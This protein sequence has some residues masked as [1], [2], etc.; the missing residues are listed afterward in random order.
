MHP[1]KLASASQ[2]L[3]IFVIFY[4]L[5]VACNAEKKDKDT[6]VKAYVQI[7][8][9]MKDVMWKGALDGQ[10]SLDTLDQK[11]MLN[12][13]GPEAF[14]TGELL[15]IDGK[16][17]VGRVAT[18]TSMAIGQTFDVKA[19][20]F[21]Y[22]Y[23]AEWEKESIPKT[24]KSLTDFENW[25][26]LKIQNEGKPFAFKL[27]GS[28]KSAK[29]HLQNLPEGTQVSSPAEAHQG[30]QTYSVADKEVTVLGFFS[31]AHQGV[32][33]HHDSFIHLHLITKDLSLMGHV[34]SLVFGNSPITL[35]LPK[36]SN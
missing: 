30:Q 36:G 32:F 28:I 25:L 3:R 9:A 18:D 26:D 4:L 31:R 34:D 22:S 1:K 13:L 5:L 2:P 10:I 35:H 12:G 7:E 8:G 27:T 24:L 17:Y 21:V 15:V 29:I 19:P 16:S 33:T 23:V 14:L 11:S 6:N 20:F